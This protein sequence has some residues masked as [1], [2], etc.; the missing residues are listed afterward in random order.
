VQQSSGQANQLTLSNTVQEYRDN[1]TLNN[2]VQEYRVNTTLN[3]TVKEYRVNTTLYNTEQEYVNIGF[4]VSDHI[5][6]CPDAQ[7]RLHI[8][9]HVY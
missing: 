9:K 6:K 7:I 1:T 3:N 5:L 4:A 8:E 2:T